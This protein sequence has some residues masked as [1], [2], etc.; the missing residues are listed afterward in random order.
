MMPWGYF[1]CD[2]ELY[3]FGIYFQGEPGSSGYLPASFRSPSK[4]YIELLSFSQDHWGF[5]KERLRARR[6][7]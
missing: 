6:L 1:L 2:G 5:H 4:P 3:L 7:K